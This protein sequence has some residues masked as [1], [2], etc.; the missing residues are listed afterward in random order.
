MLP[1]GYVGADLT[2]LC[3]EAAAIA[4]TRIFRELGEADVAQQQLTQQ[5]KALPPS[6]C[7]RGEGSAAPAAGGGGSAAVAV[8]GE[9]KAGTGGFPD[10]G[11]AAGGARASSLS[12]PDQTLD[13]YVI[14]S[15]RCGHALQLELWYI[16]VAAPMVSIPSVSHFPYE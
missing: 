8:G 13:Q 11:G 3:K 16:A 10:E 1:T 7:D 12:L 4:V 14:T 2:A 15:S 6:T 5:H 9:D